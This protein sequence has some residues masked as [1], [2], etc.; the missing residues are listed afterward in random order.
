MPPNWVN[1]HEVFFAYIVS[2]TFLKIK[3]LFYFIVTFSNW[4][5]L[6][7]HQ[8]CICN[9]INNML[10]QNWN[11]SEI[12][13]LFEFFFQNCLDFQILLCILF[14]SFETIP[15]F[16]YISICTCVYLKREINFFWMYISH[17]SD[18][19]NLSKKCKTKCGIYSQCYINWCCLYRFNG[20]TCIDYFL[21]PPVWHEH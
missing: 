3:I 1:V 11:S 14:I 21:W 19:H 16:L 4:K 9:L 7:K 2:F 13:S 17:C 18:V 8:S 10:K 6:F 12:V 5:K 15:C 20:Y